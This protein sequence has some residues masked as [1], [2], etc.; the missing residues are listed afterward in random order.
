MTIWSTK[1]HLS[2]DSLKDRNTLLIRH[3]LRTDTFCL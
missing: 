3:I 1:T 2:Y